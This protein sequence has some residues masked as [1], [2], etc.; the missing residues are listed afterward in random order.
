MFWGTRNLQPSTC[1]SQPGLPWFSAILALLLVLSFAPVVFGLEAFVY[2]D[3]AQFSY[4]IAF[5]FRESF[6]RG[7]WPF[8]NPLNNCG[9]PFVAQ[10]NTLTLYP[11]SLFYLLLPLPWSFEI[12]CLGH[13]FLAG[14]GMDCL[15]MRWTGHRL[16][17]AVAGIAF[18]FNGLTWCGLMWP[19]L[20]AALGWMPW[21][22]LAVEEAWRR[23]GR[24]IVLAACVAALQI[25]TGGAEYVL[26]TWLLLGA[27]WLFRMARRGD[28]RLLPVWRMPAVGVLALGL[29]A[30]QLLPFLDL[31]EHSERSTAYA[32]AASGFASMPLSGWA[33]Y[34]VPLFHCVRNAEG[35]FVQPD[36]TWVSSYYLGIGVLLLAAFALWRVRNVRIWL[37]AAVAAAGMLLA[38]GSPG[39]VYD[40]IKR[41]VP[42]AGFVRFPVKF[43]LLVN[44]AVPLLAAFGLA[45]LFPTSNEVRQGVRSRLFAIGLVLCALTAG[46]GWFA[47]RFPSPGSDIAATLRCAA[48]RTFFLGLFAGLLALPGVLKG[49]RW[50]ELLQAALLVTLWMDVFTHA[51]DLCPAAAAA[52]YRS[53]AVRQSCG[54]TNQAQFGVSRAMLTWDAI[55]K[56]ASGGS[57]DPQVD[58]TARRLALFMNL[59][60]LDQAAK[61][62]GFYPCNLR[63]P[64]ELFTHVYLETNQASR[65]KDFLGVSLISNPTNPADWVER[66][67][68]LPLVTAGQHPAFRTDDVSLQALLGTDF[69]PARTVYL[70]LEAQG[71]VQA[72]RQAKVT[73]GSTRFSANRLAMT[74]ESDNPAMVVVAQAYYHNWHA[75]V[76][77]RQTPLWRANY[78]FQ[79]L[80]VPGGVHQVTLQYEDQMFRAGALISGV[81]AL[82]CLAVWMLSPGAA[83]TLPSTATI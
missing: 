23:G 60:L 3:A 30:V 1:N 41:V 39:H 36:Q 7:E 53:D 6:W 78:A 45:H 31:L 21:V 49:A 27:W 48:G 11:P 71:R 34:L 83:R 16:A 56:I 35:V 19:S 81:F 43:L 38:L 44:F 22:M 52:V 14:L 51:P 18:A 57:A 2:M 4:P 46:I 37:L 12:F 33:N 40:W 28:P 72:G 24:R 73:V 75:Y 68:F 9:T 69:D 59:N 55:W 25:L 8:W 63:Y 77:G 17:A 67:S 80:E 65:L 42:A 15:A 66:D 26:L 10:W 32:R 50:K 47:W 70:P 76:D 5:H 20:T 29:A 62:D 13:L 82:A 61:V 54:W 74:V 58:T 64:F 79:A